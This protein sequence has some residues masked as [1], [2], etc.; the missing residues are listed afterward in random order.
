MPIT[1]NINKPALRAFAEDL[2]KAKDADPNAKID[3]KQVDELLS[4]VGDRWFTGTD[5][6]RSRFESGNMSL[7]E[8][9]E[10]AKKGVSGSEKDDLVAFATDPAI[11][12]MITGSAA[13]VLSSLAGVQ[14]ADSA[15]GTTATTAAS[16]GSAA[17]V[18]NMTFTPAQLEAVKK[19]KELKS[20]GQLRAMYDAATG[21]TDNAQMKTEAMELFNALPPMG[22]TSNPQSF[23]DAGLWVSAPKGIEEMHKTAR[24]LPGRQVLVKTSVNSEVFDGNDFLKYQDGGRE[25]I[26]Y[27]ATISGEDGDNFLIKVD[28][29]DEPISVPK[30]EVFNLNQPHDVGSAKNGEHTYRFGYGTR[31]NYDDPFTKAKVAEAALDIADIVAQIDY[32]KMATDADG[33]LMGRIGGSGRQEIVKLQR[34]AV[35]GIHDVINMK[36]PKG[37]SWKEPGRVRGS[38]L[39]RQAMKGAGV[40]FDQQGVMLGMLAPFQE[41][42]GVDIQAISG[43]VYR[44]IRDRGE[45]PFRGGAHG[46]LQ[47]TYRP[48]M[49]LR[50]VDRT[51]QQ[52]DHPADRA[53]SRWGDRYPAGFVSGLKQEKVGDT[54]VNCSGNISVE[55]FDRQFGAQGADGRDNHMSN[56]Q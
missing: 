13:S 56:N 39:G 30:Q 10:L 35:G 6:L 41:A 45:N 40:C 8:K 29:R 36:Y 17:A 27:R 18:S 32:T 55:T 16:G 50:I 12:S 46:W 2:A 52:S 14:F 51:W 19:F 37:S 25:G 22:P 15:G 7:D 9:L 47:L 20:S 48:S 44:N 42:L 34:E 26:T 5:Y 1:N 4:I 49:E 11:A 53:Y 24:Y 28:G 31:A 33:G 21:T 3:E 23:V 43:G 54:D 38:D